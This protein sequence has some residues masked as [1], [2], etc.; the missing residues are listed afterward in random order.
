MSHPQASRVAYLNWNRQ[1][2]YLGAYHGKQILDL[3]VI[4]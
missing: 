3:G 2:V 4:T 1:Y